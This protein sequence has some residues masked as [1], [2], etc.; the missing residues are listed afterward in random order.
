MNRHVIPWTTKKNHHRDSRR[1]ERCSTC[2]IMLDQARL[3]RAKVADS[4]GSDLPCANRA[5]SSMISH[6]KQR[7][8]RRESRWWFF[9]FVQG[10]ILSYSRE[11]PETQPR[12]ITT[13]N[14]ILHCGKSNGDRPH[15]ELASFCLKGSNKSG[16][17][18]S[19]NCSRHSLE[20]LDLYI[21]REQNFPCSFLE[22]WACGAPL[23]LS[24]TTIR[25]P[26]SDSWK[27]TLGASIQPTAM[28]KEWT[29][30]P[31]MF[32]NLE[33]HSIGA[34]PVLQV[35]EIGICSSHTLKGWWSQPGKS[36]WSLWGWFSH[37]CRSQ[38]LFMILFQWSS[39]VDSHENDKRWQ[40]KAY[41]WW[42]MHQSV[43]PN[44]T[45][46]RRYFSVEWVS[47]F[48]STRISQPKTSGTLLRS[49]T[50]P[51]HSR[52]RSSGERERGGGGG[53]GGA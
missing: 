13:F 44:A 18:N 52:S 45:F 46:C 50:M 27:Y 22:S 36:K 51:S 14:L 26:R 32:L 1:E 5:W 39:V 49:R 35:G 31:T 20:T 29:Q 41:K 42:F 25:A 21:S 10:S 48:F 43:Q 4:R 12:Q 8:S 28:V 33:I 37:F 16:L 15:M 40:S 3:A 11:Q 7:S 9:F 38:F 17:P 53:G 23:Q 24:N 2:D 34:K 6:V 30:K 47:M 19:Q